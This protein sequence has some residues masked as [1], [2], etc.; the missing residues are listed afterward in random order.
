MKELYFKTPVGIIRLSGEKGFVKKLEFVSDFGPDKSDNF[1]LDCKKQIL[2]YLDKKRKIFTCPFVIEGTEFQKLVL[3]EVT[4]IP[5][6][7]VLTY[8]E[9]AQRIGRPESVRAVANANRT[10]KIPILIPCHRVIGSNGNLTGYS[11]GI[12]IKKYLLEIE[13]FR[14]F[15]KNK[16]FFLAK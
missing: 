12:M 9:L 1:L 10:N 16:Q 6:G 15:E 8:K 13:G 4:K 3:K 2:E 7:K 11:S 5:F 14:I